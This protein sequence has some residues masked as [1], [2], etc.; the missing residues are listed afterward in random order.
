MANTV[1]GLSAITQN[2]HREVVD[3]ETGC[4]F[5]KVHPN[6]VMR[7]R[8]A[9]D[10]AADFTID[11]PTV[12][13]TFGFSS[14]QRIYVVGYQISTVLANTI[15]FK[16]KTGVAAAINLMTYNL[17]ATAILDSQSMGE[18]TNIVTDRGAALLV[19]A[20]GPATIILHYVFATQ[21]TTD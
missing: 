4:C 3:L 17:G 11:D 19:N 16:T 10:T 12:D 5:S 20:S 18:P 6:Q 15:T 13:N 7:A 1:N 21:G 8:V 9:L 14:S 2:S